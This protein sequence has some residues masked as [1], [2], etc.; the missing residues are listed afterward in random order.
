MKINCLGDSITEGWGL[1]SP[2]NQSFPSLLRKQFKDDEFCNYG[3][4]GAMVQPFGCEYTKTLPYQVAMNK[5]ADLSMLLLGSNDAYAWGPD[6]KEHY[7]DLVNTIPGPLILITP[8]KMGLSAN[9]IPKIR[10][11]I[12]D[13]GE[14][15]NLPVFDLYEASDRS[16]LGSD[17]VHPTVEGQQKIAK[18]IAGKL[19]PYLKDKEA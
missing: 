1:P 6:F 8:P 4:A 10:K 19:E 18:F 12:L 14:E 11:D 15:L 17:Q 13:L 9:N 3:I 2:E 7:K 16:W 5:P